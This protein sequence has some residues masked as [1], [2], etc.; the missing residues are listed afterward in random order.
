MN[1]LCWKY[2]KQNIFGCQP[3]KTPHLGKSRCLVLFKVRSICTVSKRVLLYP[4]VAILATLGGDPCD[5]CLDSKVNLKP[6]MVVLG[7]RNPGSVAT[8]L[9]AEVKPGIFRRSI[10]IQLRRSRQCG[11][12]KFPVLHSKLNLAYAHLGDREACEAKQ[13]GLMWV[14][15]PSLWM[16]ILVTGSWR[17]IKINSCPGVSLF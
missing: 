11:I 3:W 16:Y 14:S 5:L 7:A 12:W 13:A 9:R 8:T 6:L 2:Q 17:E 1:P 10:R 4:M 15:W